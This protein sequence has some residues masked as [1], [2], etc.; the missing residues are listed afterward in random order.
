MPNIYGNI[1]DLCNNY[2]KCYTYDT[3]NSIEIFTLTMHSNKVY[4]KINLKTD[5]IWQYF[6]RTMGVMLLATINW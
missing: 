3:F 6:V 1:V 5:F 2:F 4:S